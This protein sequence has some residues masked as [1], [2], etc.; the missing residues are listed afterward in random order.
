M[1][2]CPDCK[3]LTQI[4]DFLKKEVCFRCQYAKKMAQEQLK[5]CKHCKKI[6]KNKKR[7]KYCSLQCAEEGARILKKNYWTATFKIEKISWRDSFII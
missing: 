6:L 4:N 5:R 1:M 2:Q 3:R 7:W